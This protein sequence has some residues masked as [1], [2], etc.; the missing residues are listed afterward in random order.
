MQQIVV[1]C[2]VRVNRHHLSHP[3]S[4]T[5]S[6]GLWP[7]ARHG[8][9]KN[10]S[11]RNTETRNLRLTDK[12]DCSREGNGLLPLYTANSLQ[13]RSSAAWRYSTKQTKPNQIESNQW[14]N[15]PDGQALTSTGRRV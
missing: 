6:L 2:A 15:Q 1:Y 13:R 3:Q 12:C 11:P 14:R 9:Q 8:N 10:C 4:D 7:L 5:I